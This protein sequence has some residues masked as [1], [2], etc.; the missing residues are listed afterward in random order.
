MEVMFIIMGFSAAILIVLGILV[1]EAL[2][3]EPID[4][5]FPTGQ[6]LNGGAK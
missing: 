1:K 5:A 4:K 3:M 6:T 2:D